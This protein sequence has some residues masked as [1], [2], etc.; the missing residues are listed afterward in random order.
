[1]GERKGAVDYL[2]H[3]GCLMLMR[4]SQSTASGS[5]IAMDSTFSQLVLPAKP[6]RPFFPPGSVPVVA[7]TGRYR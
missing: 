2:A 5:A 4:D 6:K 1:M 7:S 3:G